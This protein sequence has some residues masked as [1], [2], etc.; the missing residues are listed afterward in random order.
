MI[1]EQFLARFRKSV[2]QFVLVPCVQTHQDGLVIL[3]GF[4]LLRRVEAA[5]E[6]IALL[7]GP[8]PPV[9]LGLA[10]RHP[11]QAHQLHLLVFAEGPLE[12]LVFPV[13]S[14][15]DIENPVRASSSV[16]GD[17]PFVVGLCGFRRDLGVVR[18]RLVRHLGHTELIEQNPHSLRSQTK[19]C[20]VFL[21]PLANVPLPAFYQAA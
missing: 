2:L 16:H 9:V 18:L 8:A 11:N 7:A 13:R 14:A 5:I 6:R 10:F 20:G 12:E 15:R 3:L 1:L 21:V 19:A 17:R 4:V